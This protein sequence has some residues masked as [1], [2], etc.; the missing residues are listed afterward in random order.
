M[1]IKTV[2]G[3]AC[4]VCGI[5]YDNPTQADV[6]R[7]NHELLYVPMSRTELNR[8][9]NALVLGDITIVPQSLLETLRKYARLQVIS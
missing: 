2:D 1:S 5:V 4:S 8:L 7:D 6:C 3:Y 9:L